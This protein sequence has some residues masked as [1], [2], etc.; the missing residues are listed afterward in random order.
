MQRLN[1]I[2]VPTDLSERSRRA[3]GYGCQLA[4]DNKA[5]LVI[6]HVTNELNAWEMSGEYEMFAGNNARLWPLDRIISEA[7]LDL[8]HFI[9]PH[10]EQLKQIATTTKRVVLGNVP[11]RIAAMA[12]DERADLIILSPQRS[13]RLRHWLGGGITDRVT[14]LSPC[15]VLSIT[16]P[17]PS[18]PWRG[19]LAPLFFGS[20][21]QR[22]A[23]I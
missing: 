10:L 3:L 17:L 1:K 20:P 15:P 18:Q 4:V 14:R 19:K 7:F 9:E 16:Q 23:E 8:N 5:T 22:A 11:E 2:L 13:R 12:E 21:K 6:L